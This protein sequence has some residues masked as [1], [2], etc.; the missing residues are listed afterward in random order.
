MLHNS[1]TIKNI[2]PKPD[3]S[4]APLENLFWDY[5]Y[6]YNGKELYEFVLGKKEMAD[7]DRNQVKARIWWFTVFS[8]G[9]SYINERPI[10]LSMA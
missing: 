1:E 3:V 4:L 6:P 2:D 8:C 5:K 7:L 9:I 10:F